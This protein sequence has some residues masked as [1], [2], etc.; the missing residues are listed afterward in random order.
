[1]NWFLLSFISALFSAVSAVSEKK[2]L[3]SLTP[4]NFSFL[5]SAATLIFTIP[6]FFNVDY[7]IIGSTEMLLLFIK[8]ILGAAAFL[9]VMT[10]IKNLEI[11]QALPLLAVTP[12]LVAIS[13]ALFI[14]DYL[15]LYDWTGILLMLIGAYIIEMHRGEMKLLHPFKALFNFSKYSYVFYALILFTISSLLDRVLLKDYLLPPYTFMAFQQLFYFLIFLAI[16]LYRNKTLVNEFKGLNKKLIN[17]LILI[18]IFTVIYRYTQ[19]EATKLAPVALVLSV[20][21]LSILFAVI[22]GGKLFKEKNL[23]LRITAVIMILAGTTL[24]MITSI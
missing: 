10:A 24:L 3:F 20:K 21:R 18:S 15:T 1:M 7:S 5:V 17:L 16:I 2:A 6:F 13:G 22:F 8:T 23:A 12:G 4:L 9:C 19:I 14:N 11:S